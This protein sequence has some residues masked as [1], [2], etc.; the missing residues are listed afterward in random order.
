M[1]ISIFWIFLY[2]ISGINIANKNI[3]CFLTSYLL[4]I[5]LSVDNVF[6]WFLIFKSLK[7]PIIH[8]KK[9]LSYGLLGAFVLRFIFSFFSFFVFSKWHWV[10]Y[11]FG[12]L[13][14]LMSFKIF[15]ISSKKENK[16]KNISLSWIYKIFRISNN[17]C[18]KNFFLKINN[19]IFFTPLFVSLILIEFSDILFSADSIPAIFSVT[20]NLFIILSSNI[21]SV[22]GLRSMY[23]FIAPIVNKFPMIE[24]ALSFILMFIGFKILFEKFIIIST[25]LTFSIIL[26]ILVSAFLINIIFIK[27]K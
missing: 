27:K 6:I 18:C 14:I 4:E 26:I 8:Q 7:I 10:L 13:F 21:F 25:F 22:L 17:S 24:Y 3:V 20:H 5:I 15:F 2:N 9:V 16:Q 23:L 11:F 19:K 1:F 12:I